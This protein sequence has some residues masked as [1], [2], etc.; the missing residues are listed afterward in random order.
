MG[1]R[2]KGAAAPLRDR[3]YAPRA[4]ARTFKGSDRGEDGGGGIAASIT[5]VLGIIDLYRHLIRRH[6]RRRR[7]RSRTVP[8]RQVRAVRLRSL[9]P[10][11]RPNNTRACI[12]ED[13]RYRRHNV[14]TNICKMYDENKRTRIIIVTVNVA[15]GSI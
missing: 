15:R 10:Y 7:R 8:R 6:R 12:T 1:A 11:A 2:R 3:V 13:T 4:V 9:Q 5:R 14:L